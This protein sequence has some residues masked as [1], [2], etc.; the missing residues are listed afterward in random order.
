MAPQQYGCDGQTRR[1]PY[2]C[3]AW[4]NR[5]KLQ[6]ETGKRKIRKSNKDQRDDGVL[7]VG[8]WRLTPI[9][10]QACGER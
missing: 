2:G 8:S 6:A 9:A 7:V 1:R 4:I 3:G 5:S 10:S